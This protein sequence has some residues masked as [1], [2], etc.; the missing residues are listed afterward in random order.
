MNEARSME[1]I[2]GISGLLFAT[3]F[4]VGALIAG[5]PDGDKPAKWVDFYNDSGHRMQ[6]IIQGYLWV[7]AGL[8]LMV[9]L[10]AAYQRFGAG[11]GTSGLYAKVAGG[12]AALFGVILLVGGVMMANVAGNVAFGGANV[13]K[14]G[15]L[16]IQLSG[17]GMALVLLAGGLSA[18]LA[19]VAVSL[20]II[21]EQ[22]PRWLAVLGFVAA[23]CGILGVVFLPMV[24]VSIWTICAAVVLLRGPSQAAARKPQAAAA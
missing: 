3:L 22:G 21:R 8:A 16:L 10:V 5:T 12:A 11:T 19:F 23:I 7:I 6:L 4:V 9:F 24:A 13:P 1:R 18:A 20:L 2:A 14:D 17:Q 15:D